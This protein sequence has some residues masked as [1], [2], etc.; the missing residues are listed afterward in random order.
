MTSAFSFINKKPT[1]TKINPLSSSLIDE[2][3]DSQEFSSFINQPSSSSLVIE[4]PSRKSAFNFISSSPPSSQITKNLHNN[5]DKQKKSLWTLIQSKKKKHSLELSNLYANSVKLEQIKAQIDQVVQEKQQAMQDESFLLARD[6]QQ[7]EN[8]Y[9]KQLSHL[10]QSRWQIRAAWKKMAEI[11]MD[12]AERSE[13]VVSM[14]EDERDARRREYDQYAKNMDQKDEQRLE[15]IRLKRQDIQSQ[16]SEI[17]L[18]IEIWK[19]NDTEIQETMYEM[20]MDEIEK[21]KELEEK[22][23]QIQNEIDALLNRVN[24]LK[25]DKRKHDNQIKELETIMEEK[26]KPLTNKKIDHEQ[27]LEMIKQRQKETEEKSSQLDEEDMKANLEMK[28]HLDEKSRGQKEI[29]ELER[30]IAIIK[31]RKLFGKEEAQQVL[32]VLQNQ[33]ETRD[34]AV[35][36]EQAK[37]KQAKKIITDKIKEIDIIQSNEY[38]HEQRKVQLDSTILQL[39]AKWKNLNDQKQLAIE[40]DQFEKAAVLSDQIKLTEQQ[41]DKAEKEKESLQHDALQLSLSEKR[42]ELKDKKEEYKVLELEVE[43]NIISIL[44]SS[45]RELNQILSR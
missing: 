27:E 24:L 43:R 3:Y 23:V 31:N 40:T 28:V 13:D 20:V 6:L 41:L 17:T 16:R 29:E 22:S 44:T 5:N 7:R 36:Q 34:Q 11:L 1:K 18:D 30:N 33:L 37:L 8:E 42:K 14:F 25:E 32:D 39:S 10:L 15:E 19:R 35:D 2:L 9:R 45:Q 21:K 26:L 4:T 12:E 38:E